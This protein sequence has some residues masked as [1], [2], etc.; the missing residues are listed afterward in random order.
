M[1]S[2]SDGKWRHLVFRLQGGQFGGLLTDG[3]YKLA[4]GVG[5]REEEWRVQVLRGHSGGNVR[6]DW[7]V[8]VQTQGGYKV[9]GSLAMSLNIYICVCM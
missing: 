7:A 8:S 2:E 6:C 3:A 4:V 1:E 5:H 9:S